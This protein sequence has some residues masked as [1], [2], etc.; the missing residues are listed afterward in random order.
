N[1]MLATLLGGHTA[2]EI[3]FD[4]MT[5]GSQNDIERATKIARMMVTEYGMSDKL[6]PRT[7]GKREELVFLGKE[8]S[9]QRDYSD[10]VAE[11]ID[12]EVHDIIDRAYNV[13]QDILTK[14]KAKL[15]QIAERLM[16]EETLEGKTLDALFDSPLPSP[17]PA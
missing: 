1:D 9:E 13:A 3:I 14:N 6:G 10:K 7:F 17:A 8:I 2:E 5:T 11:D 16:A 4:E 12:A 15:I